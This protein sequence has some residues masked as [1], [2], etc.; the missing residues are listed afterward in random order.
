MLTDKQ[1]QRYAD[2][3]LW[4]LKTAR[5][6]AFQKNEIVAIHYHRPAIVLAETLFAKLLEMGLHP[7]QQMLPTPVMETDFYSLANRRQLTFIPPGDRKL[8]E[9]LNGRIFLYAPESITHLGGIDPR[10]IGVT[11][12]ARKFLRDI[13]TRREA[14]GLFGWTLCIYPT[15]ELARQSG[16]SPKAYC[17]QVVRSCFLDRRRPLQQWQRVHGEIQAIKQRLGRLSI[18]RLRIES[19]HSDLEIT[20]G[21]RRKWLGLSGRNI[22]S[23]EVFLSPD[24]RGTRGVYYADQPSYRSGNSVKEVRLEFKGGRVINARAAEGEKFLRQQ[25]AMDA[26]AGRVGEF[27]LTDKRFSKINAFMANTLYD[28]NYGGK[29]GNCHVALGSSYADSY[30]GKPAG[31]TAA[32]KKSLG[33]NDSALHWDLVNTEK[34]RVTAHL[35]GDRSLTL[36]EDGRFLI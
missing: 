34:K 23:F 19:D 9:Q 13:L 24:W 36:Y 31:L 11:A 28:E 32:R 33:F 25:L 6:G 22:P 12:V 27:S 35:N 16:L 30:A 4:A 14:K 26:G 7:V 15:E 3:L 10:R 18:R 20:P 5:R 29:F 8:H 21:E 2:V 17:R 1:M